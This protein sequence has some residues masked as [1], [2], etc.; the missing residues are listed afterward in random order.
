MEIGLTGAAGPSGD[1][2]IET[3]S[4]PELGSIG[5][6]RL[7]SILG[8]GG[9]GTVYLAEQREPIYRRVA[10][11]VV[12][13]GL[14][15]K[16]VLAR[17]EAERQALAL[18]THPGIAKVL[19]AGTTADGSPYFAM[20]YV[21]GE[22][23]TDYC[24]RKRLAMQDRLELFREVCAA[25]QHAHQRGI[26]H[27]DLKPSN[28][29]VEEVDG[30]P[31][32]KVI[33][34]G[35]AKAL[36]QRLTERTLF[37]ERGA[38]V[39]TPE[40]MSPEQAAGEAFDVDTRTDVYSLG[41]VLYELL[42]GSLPHD[43]QRLREAGW[44]GMMKI[45]RE[46]EAKKPSTKVS[47]FNEETASA[48]ASKRRTEPKSLRRS[49]AGDLDWILLK[50]LD[51]ERERRYPNV[52]DFASDIDRHLTHVP[53]S[54]GPASTWH[55]ATRFA[56][57][58][59]WGV[60]TAAL[61][62]LFLAAAALVLAGAL[63][64]E[65]AARSTAESRLQAQRLLSGFY[66]SLFREAAARVAAGGAVSFAAA[67]RSAL[68]EF[69]RS[70][71]S[72][73]PLAVAQARIGVSELLVRLDLGSEALSVLRAALEA[74]RERL[75]VDSPELAATKLVLGSVL[76]DMDCCDDDA[77]EREGNALLAESLRVFDALDPEGREAAEA[78]CALATSSSPAELAGIR[79]DSSQ[80]CLERSRVAFGEHS[81]R[82]VRLLI[83]FGAE[84]IFLG[85]TGA[86]RVTA[87]ERL[88]RAEQLASVFQG[89]ERWRSAQIQLFLAFSGKPDEPLQR[90]RRSVE[91]FTEIL[92][93]GDVE[94]ALAQL[95]LG[96]SLNEPDPST[97]GIALRKTAIETLAKV[98]GAN[99]PRIP[100]FR[101]EG[102]ETFFHIGQGEETLSQEYALAAFEIVAARSR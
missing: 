75:P 29:L 23:I 76:Q 100:S 97:E 89:R 95:A 94:T 88:L 44:L 64:R 92:G 78:F 80:Q 46:E 102:R 31:R 90:L 72:L 85:A 83:G 52:S 99:D 25:V 5:P 1:T 26:L 98:W 57:R 70:A 35:L 28:L 56:R 73:D 47:T 81:P 55:R 45:L 3:P 50:A 82:Y 11:K 30:G 41:V 96:A 54:A 58:H 37:T 8:E 17:F 16:E 40:Y 65:S 39:G 66:G 15:G 71:A 14:G 62:V 9:M 6:Y 4:S 77:Q 48:V 68:T 7:V 12:R 24:D 49:L 13:A 21:Q 91:L 43:P 87:R 36:N 101:P 60:A 22:P 61:L 74:Q 38:I 84:G 79:G 69:D 53:V 10:L 19:D 34:F 33:D 42:T 93:P 51:K 67:A 18:M 59:R 27:R 20:E 86:D 32:P 2:T 63:G